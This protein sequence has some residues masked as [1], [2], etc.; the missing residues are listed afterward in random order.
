MLA[1][2]FVSAVRGHFDPAEDGAQEQAASASAGKTGRGPPF[3]GLQNGE[4]AVANAAQDSRTHGGLWATER[5]QTESYF[6]CYFFYKSHFL[7]FFV[8]FLSKSHKVFSTQIVP[9]KNLFRK[10]KSN[11]IFSKMFKVYEFYL[12]FRCK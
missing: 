6:H 11:G 12:F 8:H 2:V 9:T 5:P 10:Y 4:R 1:R 7:L 3:T